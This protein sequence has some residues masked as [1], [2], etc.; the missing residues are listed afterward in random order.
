[1]EFDLFNGV[2]RVVDLCAA[3]GSWSQVLSRILILREK[4]GRSGWATKTDH[5]KTTL[6]TSSAAKDVHNLH[7]D[8]V[9]NRPD[10][11]RGQDPMIVAV[12]LQPMAPLPGIVTLRADIT[13]PSTIPLLL[14]A[15]DPDTDLSERG[16]A[17][18]INRVDLVISDGAPDVTG[19]HDL[20]IY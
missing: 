4:V 10:D 2:S 5:Q 9:T 12:D 19:L 14:A 18:P 7:T 8:Y 13:H 1:E 17:D 15:L 11:F 16:T 20:D 3:P 6:Q